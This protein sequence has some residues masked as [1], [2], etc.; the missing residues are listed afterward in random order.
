MSRTIRT[1]VAVG[2]VLAF[3][4]LVCGCGSKAKDPSNA[5]KTGLKASEKLPPKAA[6]PSAPK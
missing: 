5:Q 4:A 2:L 3:A 6:A 1:L